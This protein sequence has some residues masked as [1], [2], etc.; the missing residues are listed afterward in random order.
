MP[1]A[2]VRGNGGPS[3][4]MMSPMQQSQQMAMQQQQMQQQ[5]FGQQMRPQQPPEYLQQQVS[6][7]EDR[8]LGI[9]NTTILHII[10]TCKNMFHFDAFTE[11]DEPPHTA[12]R[13]A[14]KRP[15]RPA[16]PSASPTAFIEF[17]PNHIH[18][19]LRCKRQRDNLH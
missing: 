4:P 16:A 8:Y 6:F 2:G 3:R 18:N 17:N 15:R 7:A 13:D 5:Q 9:I 19:E 1:G 14:V 12:G 10:C 11:H